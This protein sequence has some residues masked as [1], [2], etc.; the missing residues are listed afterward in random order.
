MNWGITA[1]VQLL[2]AGQRI[3]TRK[4]HFLSLFVILFSGSVLALAKLDL[5]P[6]PIRAPAASAVAL[7]TSQ[8]VT[9]TAS[10]PSV[11][12]EEPVAIAIPAI[13]LAATIANPATTDI[14]VLDQALLKGAVRYPTSALLGETGNVVLF[15][16][17]SYLPVVGNQAYKT[18]D[19]IQKLVAGDVIT[20]YSAGT[21]YTYRVR[22]VAKESAASDAGIDL[23]VAGR[24][25]TLATCNSFGAKTDRFIVTADFVESHS[26]SI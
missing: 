15:G 20:V 25:L 13:N 17:S 21:A 8:A 24:E 14:E 12:A 4:W 3:S 10:V 5:L 9:A 2:R 1:A 6:E 7:A 23:A 22:G 18:F 11:R 19:G 26:I 16:H